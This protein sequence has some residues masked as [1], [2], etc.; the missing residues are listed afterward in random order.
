MKKKISAVFLVLVICYTL[1]PFFHISTSSSK[2]VYRNGEQAIFT[3]SNKS[4]LDG[5]VSNVGW[6][7]EKREGNAWIEVQG[8]SAHTFGLLYDFPPKSERSH[9]F[10]LKV[11]ESGEYRYGKILK[12]WGYTFRY[13]ARFSVK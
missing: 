6:V 5:R 13:H 9:T 11:F 12:I 3:L 4:L 1:I 2:D 8:P 10:E 7:I